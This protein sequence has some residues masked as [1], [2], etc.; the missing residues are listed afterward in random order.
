MQQQKAL[1]CIQSYRY[2]HHTVYWRVK[3]KLSKIKFCSQIQWISTSQRLDLMLLIFP[4][5]TFRLIN[6]IYCMHFLHLCISKLLC[7]IHVLLILRKQQSFVLFL[8]LTIV[9]FFIYSFYYLFK[10]YHLLILIKYC[11][12]ITMLNFK[13]PQRSMKNLGILENSVPVYCKHN[14]SDFTKHFQ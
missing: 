11:V 14:I 4:W 1:H 7:R 13:L 6:Q 10:K 9:Y 5:R 3:I 2:V 8:N 12:S